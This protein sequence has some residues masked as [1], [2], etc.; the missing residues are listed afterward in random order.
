MVGTKTTFVF[1]RQEKKQSQKVTSAFRTSWTM[2]EYRLS[3]MNA[4]GCY[5]RQNAAIVNVSSK[6]IPD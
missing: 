3:E 5:I 6:Q 2:D 4:L 1:H